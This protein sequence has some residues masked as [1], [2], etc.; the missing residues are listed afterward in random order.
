MK[1]EVQLGVNGYSTKAVFKPEMYDGHPPLDSVIYNTRL[2][3]L[4]PNVCAVSL[5]IVLQEF[6]A[7]SISYDSSVQVHVAEA[8]EAFLSSRRCRVSPVEQTPVAIAT[9]NRRAVIGD[10]AGGDCG[11]ISFALGDSSSF[12]SSASLKN[13][14]ISS[15][16]P[17]F[18][19]NNESGFVS[20]S[21]S[22]ATFVA[23]DYAFSEIGLSKHY[24]Q[25]LG[26]SEVKRYQALLA[27]VNLKLTKENSSE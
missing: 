2:R 4:D 10:E 1:V 22:A 7:E 25:L 13:V 19:P 6:A 12:S 3:I 23:P 21:L 18:F 11:D 17:G 26:E 24:E 15:N 20:A 16:L 27:S 8:I 14:H 9:G 5:A